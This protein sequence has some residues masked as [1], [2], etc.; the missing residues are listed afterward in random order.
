MFI[1]IGIKNHRVK[2]IFSILISGE[3]SYVQKN[4]F[5]FALKTSDNNFLFK[6]ADEIYPV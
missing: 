4:I 3:I 1:I 5:K 2:L 6:N